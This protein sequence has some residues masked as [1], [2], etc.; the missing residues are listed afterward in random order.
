M[1]GTFRD[2]RFSKLKGMQLDDFRKQVAYLAVNYE[3]ASLDSAIAYLRGEYQ[4]TRPLCLLTFDD[5]VREHGEIVTPIL[6][7]YKISGIFGIITQCVAEQTVAAV[8]MNHL[9]MAVWDF[10]DYQQRFM[11][12]FSARTDPSSFV[13]DH[14]KAAK[15]IAG[16]RP[17]WRNLSSS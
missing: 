13:I 14:D 15:R 2:D 12:C 4:A 17:T 10:A 11:H 9:L 6:A 5:G 7:D 8:H 3:M 16:T 1:C